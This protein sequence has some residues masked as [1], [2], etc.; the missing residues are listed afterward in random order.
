MPYEIKKRGHLYSVV[1]TQTGHI[2]SR[3][4]SRDKAVR[5]MRL[6]YMLENK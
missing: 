3:G 4:T 1:N 5:Q 2:H 6:L